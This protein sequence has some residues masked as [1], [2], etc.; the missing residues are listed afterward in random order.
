MKEFCV[1]VTATIP[2]ETATAALERAQAAFSMGFLRV[3]MADAVLVNDTYGRAALRL[4]VYDDCSIGIGWITARLAVEDP[5]F[6][7]VPARPYAPVTVGVDLAKE[8]DKTVVWPVAPPVAHFLRH[9]GTGSWAAYTNAGKKERF[10]SF[11][12]LLRAHEKTI[13]TLDGNLPPSS[14]DILTVTI[15]RSDDG[16]SWVACGDGKPTLSFDSLERL[17]EACAPAIFTFGRALE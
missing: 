9:K 17:V 6:E 16:G 12:A 2:A 1:T 3:G 8:A 15:V 10:C 14:D 4:A 5:D 7:E 11:E 13:I